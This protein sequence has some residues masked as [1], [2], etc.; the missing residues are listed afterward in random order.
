MWM[1][2]DDPEPSA[3]PLA[4]EQLLTIIVRVWDEAVVLA[5]IGRVGRGSSLRRY[6]A[7]VVLDLRGQLSG[8]GRIGGVGTG[9]TR[10]GANAADRGLRT[11]PGTAAHTDH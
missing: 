3:D 5:V 1:A 6:T 11:S 7:L 4:P 8:L 2:C 9:R 10:R